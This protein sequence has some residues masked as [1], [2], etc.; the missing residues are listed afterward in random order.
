MT[1]P[2]FRLHHALGL[3]AALIFTLFPVFWMVST[4]FKPFGE[5]ATVPPPWVP[6]DFT[7]AN[8]AP[9]YERY[10][11]SYVTAPKTGL[12]AILDSF[13]IAA[14]TTVLALVIGLLAAIGFSRYRAGSDRLA[15]GILA[16][17][18]VPPITLAISGALP[19]HRDGPAR[20]PLRHHPRAH[21]L[22]RALLLLDAEELHR[23][24]ARR[25]SRRPA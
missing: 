14:G 4:S 16:V 5:W 15:V 25:R 22:R 6:R 7:L 21:G 3:A 17:R 19:L 8:Y 20:H 10:E 13:I 1:S 18:A 24:G 23:R 12:G 2:R 11:M 9:L